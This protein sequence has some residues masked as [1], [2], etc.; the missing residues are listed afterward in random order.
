MGVGNDA[1]VAAEVIIRRVER[2]RANGIA[3]LE[4]CLRVGRRRGRSPK[5]RY[6]H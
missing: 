3:E 4:M 5:W 6:G 1:E 2:D